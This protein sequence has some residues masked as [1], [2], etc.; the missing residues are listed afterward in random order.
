MLFSEAKCKTKVELPGKMALQSDLSG[1]DGVVAIHGTKGRKIK[2]LNENI[3]WTTDRHDEAL[4]HY[5]TV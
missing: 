3:I 5:L 2:H 4:V 1:K